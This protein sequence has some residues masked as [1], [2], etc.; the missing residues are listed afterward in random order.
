MELLILGDY[1]NENSL[2]VLDEPENNFT[3]D[4]KLF[5]SDKFASL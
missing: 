4:G 3:R 2:I 5:M 1:V